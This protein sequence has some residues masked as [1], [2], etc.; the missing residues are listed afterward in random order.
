MAIISAV[1]PIAQRRV[2]CVCKS[3]LTA[4]CAKQ[5][6]LAVVSNWK[7]EI[8]EP[9]NDIARAE[10][11]EEGSKAYFRHIHEVLGADPDLVMEVSNTKATLVEPC[12]FAVI[13]LLFN[14]CIPWDH[15]CRLRTSK[16]P[17]P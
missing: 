4:T 6:P 8:T 15:G 14:Q 17:H 13:G 3:Y 1:F 9:L 11:S 7:G 16:P 12:I 5:D 2:S 10:A